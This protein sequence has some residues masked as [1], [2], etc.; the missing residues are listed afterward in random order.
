[1]IYEVCK[2]SQGGRQTMVIYFATIAAKF[3][4]RDKNWLL[5]NDE[6]LLR[7]FYVVEFKNVTCQM[8]FFIVSIGSLP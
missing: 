3:V 8:I 5:S 4:C 7:L 6:N 2:K 1:M